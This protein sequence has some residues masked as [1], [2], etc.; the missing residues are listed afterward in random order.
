MIRLCEWRDRL[1]IG[2]YVLLGNMGWDTAL[3]ENWG[4][5]VL[6]TFR[7]NEGNAARIALDR[8]MKDFPP[9]LRVQ[10]KP[11]GA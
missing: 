9:D 1:N 3:F 5:T 10:E 8:A 11:K 4:C 6:K 2:H 7:D